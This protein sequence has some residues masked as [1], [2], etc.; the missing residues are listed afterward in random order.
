[1][2]NPF[3]QAGSE[4]SVADSF[5]MLEELQASRSDEIRKLRADEC[6]TIK[7]RVIVQPGNTGDLHRLKIQGVTGE[8]SR[9]G[10]LVLMPT[11]LQVGDVYRLTFDRSMLDLPML[12]ARCLWCR[13]VREEAFEVGLAFFSPIE[14]PRQLDPQRA[15]PA[16]EA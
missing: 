7:S 13:L 6:V 1:M 10:C 9:I 4:R 14:L 2:H 5:M 8:L 11:P 3:E 15:D 12:F 16:I